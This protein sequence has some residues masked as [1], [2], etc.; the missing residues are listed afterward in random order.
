LNNIPQD[1][2]NGYVTIFDLK[3]RMV[4]RWKIADLAKQNFTWTWDMKDQSGCTIAKGFYVLRVQNSFFM[5]NKRII[6]K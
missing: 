6:I 3:G 4:M 2:I 1:H 5:M